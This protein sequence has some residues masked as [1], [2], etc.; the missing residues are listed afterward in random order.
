M[1]EP[2]R[3]TV[4][5]V[6]I[7][8]KPFSPRI[9]T[10]GGGWHGLLVYVPARVATSLGPQ[11]SEIPMTN[12]RFHLSLTTVLAMGLGA[13]L[14]H[15]L[16]PSTAAGYPAGVAVSYGGIQSFPLLA[17]WRSAAASPR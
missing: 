12:T 16:T 8:M 5:C 17:P 11:L 2:N 9:R 3:R 4:E 7:Q 15:A 1:A 13:T 10:K 6:P 14:T